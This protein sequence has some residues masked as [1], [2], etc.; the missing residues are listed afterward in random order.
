MCRCY[1]RLWNAPVFHTCRHLRRN[2][3]RN[4]HDRH[5]SRRLGHKRSPL[6]VFPHQHAHVVNLWCLGSAKPEEWRLG[7]TKNRSGNCCAQ[8]RWRS[9][10]FSFHESSKILGA[11]FLELELDESLGLLGW[12]MRSWFIRFHVLQNYLLATGASREFQAWRCSIILKLEHKN[13]FIRNV[14]RRLEWCFITRLYGINPPWTN[15]S[16]LHVR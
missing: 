3:A 11:G 8:H 6:R 5:P 13:F 14:L 10:H 16:S 12:P 2:G 1:Y 4:L 7:T 15:K 9:I